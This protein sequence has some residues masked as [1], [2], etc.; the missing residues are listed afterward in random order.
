MPDWTV[1]PSEIAARRLVGTLSTEELQLLIALVRGMS[2]LD[3]TASTGL[4]AG[5]VDRAR[6]SMMSK[7]G[8]TRAAEAVRIGVLARVDLVN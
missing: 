5:Q 1:D 3:M 2:A 7:L 8:A 6:A 4:D